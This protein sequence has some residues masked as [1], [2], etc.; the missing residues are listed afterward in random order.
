MVSEYYDWYS[1]VKVHTEV[2]QS[3]NTASASFSITKLFQLIGVELPW[4][5]A[6]WM[7]AK[8]FTGMRQT[9]WILI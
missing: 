9:K 2:L 1:T 5:E 4:K 8:K 6:N 7:L 3:Q